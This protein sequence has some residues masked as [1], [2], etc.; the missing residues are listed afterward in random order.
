MD[1]LRSYRRVLVDS[2]PVRPIERNLK[3]LE[4]YHRWILETL[5]ERYQMGLRL[6]LEN[7]YVLAT[8]LARLYQEQAG[9]EG[10]SPSSAGEPGE[11]SQDYLEKALYYLELAEKLYT[12]DPNHPITEIYDQRMRILMAQRKYGEAL[13]LIQSLRYTLRGRIRQDFSPAVMWERAARSTGQSLEELEAVLGIPAR[14]A[15]SEEAS[16][17]LNTA[18]NML[19]ANDGQLLEEIARQ[20]PQVAKTLQKIVHR[21]QGG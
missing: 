15:R 10:L 1:I 4:E 20:Y 18:V 16:E 17:V 3:D 14:P 13:Q 19:F 8:E 9:R 2:I 12:G 5:E 11:P 21:L 7:G 6:G